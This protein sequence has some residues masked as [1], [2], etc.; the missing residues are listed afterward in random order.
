MGRYREKREHTV[1]GLGGKKECR[2][3]PLA[4]ENPDRDVE[5]CFPKLRKRRP[6]CG[7]F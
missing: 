1:E 4:V 3:S 2:P 5:G 6:K 7:V